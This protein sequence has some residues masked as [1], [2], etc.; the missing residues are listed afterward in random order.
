MDFII[1]EIVG[2]IIIG[3][4]VGFFAPGGLFFLI[5]TLLGRESSTI[6]GEGF[7]SIFWGLL[8]F[9]VIIFCG[10]DAILWSGSTGSFVVFAAAS[11]VSFKMI[12]MSMTTT[13]DLDEPKSIIQTKPELK[14]KQPSSNK[15]SISFDN[16]AYTF[17]W[18]KK[19]KRIKEKQHCEQ[20]N[21]YSE[22]IINYRLKEKRCLL[23]GHE[24]LP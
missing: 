2:P 17:N 12:K 6:D 22:H 11:V 21:S 8:A 4:S 14:N 18:A 3:V 23:C 15:K 9:S 19:N 7:G 13:E 5:N 24:T 16:D 10:I 20:C 1:N